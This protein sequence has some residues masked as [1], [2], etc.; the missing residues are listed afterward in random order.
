MR[1][2]SRQSPERWPR[3]LR[4]LTHCTAWIVGGLA[5]CVAVV[6]VGIAM[7]PT[8]ARA[9]PQASVQ[10]QWIPLASTAPAAIQ[11]AVRRSRLLNLSMTGPGD[12]PHDVARLGVPHYVAA[13]LLSGYAN[14]TDSF[15]VPVLDANG[16]V[17]DTIVAWLNPPH[18]ALFVGYIRSYDGG[19][20]SWP[21]LPDA[22]TALAAVK[23]Q[24]GA[25]LRAG[26]TAT[27]VYFPYNYRARFAGQLHWTVGGIG[28]EDPI[29][30]VPGDDGHDHF[31]GGD[32]H[33]YHV[34]ELPL[35]PQE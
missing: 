10:P 16:R 27:L 30:R 29:W 23:T 14:P 33:A 26:A 32:G 35:A 20:A 18:T 9:A 2:H 19:L 13:L 4:A 11:N 1:R 22:T 17:T 24:H 6:C 12:H 31:V 25:K 15:V 8:P 7:A 3:V 28:P 21:T 34:G 5:V